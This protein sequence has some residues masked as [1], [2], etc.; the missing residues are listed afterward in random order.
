MNLNH[1]QTIIYTYMKNKQENTAEWRPLAGPYDLHDAHDVMYLANVICDARLLKREIEL[2]PDSDGQ[3][4]SVDIWCRWSPKRPELDAHFK[5]IIEMGREIAKVIKL[6]AIPEL[7]F[8]KG[9]IYLVGKHFE[10]PDF[11]MEEK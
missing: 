11:R 1:L 6:G 10:C 4:R 9:F 2:R 5:R 8:D 3:K 7:I